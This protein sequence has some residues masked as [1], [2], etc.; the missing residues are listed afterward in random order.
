MGAE[1]KYNW[2]LVNRGQ[3]VLLNLLQYMGLQLIIKNS[4]AREI[5]LQFS[6]AKRRGSK[7]LSSFPKALQ[8]AVHGQG[9][10]SP[11]QCDLKACDLLTTK[12]PYSEAVTHQVLS[13]GRTN[14]I[15][16]SRQANTDLRRQLGSRAAAVVQTFPTGCSRESQSYEPCFSSRLQ[17]CQSE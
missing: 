10:Y 1:S 8:L 16:F 14:V 13:P 17:G 3:D 15:I 5:Q 9:Q 6:K 12:C 4:L 7:Q 2:H 11:H